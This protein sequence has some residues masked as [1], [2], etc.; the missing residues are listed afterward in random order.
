MIS[1]IRGYNTYDD[2]KEIFTWLLYFSSY[3]VHYANF[4]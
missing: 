1:L 2:V 4:V 3:D